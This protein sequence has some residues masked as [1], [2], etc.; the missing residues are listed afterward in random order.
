MVTINHE[1]DHL[2][3]TDIPITGTE[4]A[5]VQNL[6]NNELN[7]TRTN[8][9][10]QPPQHPMVDNLVPLPETS[11]VNSLSLQEIERYEHELED[12]EDFEGPIITGID[13]ERYEDAQES[14]K[15]Y[16]NLYYSSNEVSNL[17]ALVQNAD[18]VANTNHQYYQ[19]LNGIH[20]DLD[21]NVEKKR[22]QINDVNV[23]RKKRQTVDFQP[24]NDYL[25][26]RWKDGIKSV[27]DLGIERAMND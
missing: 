11:S 4:R 6:I 2:P 21:K 5:N 16:E 3:Y 13:T 14:D 19:Q 25:N 22:K 26:N 8:D 20:Q 12:N 7:E 10:H 27:V 18:S 24:V 17:S 1:I 15:V 9:H 23:L